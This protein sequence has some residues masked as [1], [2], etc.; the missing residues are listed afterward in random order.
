MEAVAMETKRLVFSYG[1]LQD[2]EVQRS[3]YGRALQGRRDELACAECHVITIADSAVI[4]ATGSAQHANLDFNEK[5]ESRVA[6]TL[7]ELTE[8]ELAATDAYEELAD[9]KRIEVELVSGTTA[10][11]YIYWPGARHRG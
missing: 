1:T 11:T 5:S 10:W 9:Y 7:L 2:E 3:M 6:G 8:A 4:A